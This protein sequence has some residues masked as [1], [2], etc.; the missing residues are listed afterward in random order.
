MIRVLSDALWN[1]LH[2]SGL[3]TAIYCI[4]FTEHV[5]AL[6]TIAVASPVNSTVSISPPLVVCT[7]Q[8]NLQNFWG[9]TYVDS[10]LLILPIMGV[11]NTLI[12]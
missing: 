4:F 10:Q 5:L 3:G 6:L 1:S 12:I 8:K 9:E 11:K 2:F 7:D